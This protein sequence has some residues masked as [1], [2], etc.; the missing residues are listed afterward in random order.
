MAEWDPRYGPHPNAQYRKNTPTGTQNARPG[1]PP[2][3]PGLPGRTKIPGEQ[4]M[5]QSRFTEFSVPAFFPGVPAPPVATATDI[6]LR[7]QIRNI[8]PV[9]LFLSATVND[10]NNPEGPTGNV[11]RV[12]VNDRDVFV[13]A[14]EQTLYALAAGPGGLTT[15][16]I[17]DALSSD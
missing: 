1:A 5:Q 10:I 16:A 12:P 6:A 13:L 4:K 17:S 11:V 7:V 3:L 8:G 2:P 9:V 14:P 15:V